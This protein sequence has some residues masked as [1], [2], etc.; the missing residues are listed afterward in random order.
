VEIKKC[1]WFHE[2]GIPVGG[3]VVNGVIQKEQVGKN[4][5]QFVL[6]RVQMQDERRGHLEDIWR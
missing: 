6:N 3:V 2:F 5:P 4:A 1:N